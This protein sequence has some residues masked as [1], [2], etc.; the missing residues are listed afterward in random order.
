MPVDS[1]SSTRILPDRWTNAP[2]GNILRLR[3]NGEDG[4]VYYLSMNYLRFMTITNGMT[5]VRHAGAAFMALALV[6]AIGLVPQPARAA[7]LFSDGFEAPTNLGNWAAGSAWNS[8]ASAAHSGSKSARVTGGNSNQTMEKTISTAGYTTLTLSF[9]YKAD[10][11]ESYEDDRVEVY[12]S[13]NG[14][15]TWTEITSAQMDD[16]HD[17]NTWRQVTFSSFPSGANNNANFKL[18]FKGYLNSGTDK[19]WIDDVNLS[20]TAVSVTYAL[21]ITKG[22]VGSGSVTSVPTGISCGA[23][24]AENY[25]A[26]T[27]VTLTATPTTG[28]TFTGWSGACSGTGS[29]VVTMDAAKSVTATFAIATYPLTV[30]TSGSGS[31]TSVPTGISRGADC[32]ENFSFG[33]NVTLTATPT[34]GW[35][36]TGWSGACSGTGSCVVSMTDATAV[37]ATFSTLPACSDGADNDEDTFVDAQDP[38]CWTDPN[39]AETYNSADTD[40]TTPGDM[41][42]NIEG[43]QLTDDLCP[44]PSTITVTKVVSGGTLTVGDFPLF[45]GETS[46]LSGITNAFAEGVYTISETPKLDYV[47]TFSGDCSPDKENGDRIDQIDDWNAKKEAVQHAIDESS[48]DDDSARLAQIEGIN[49]KILALLGALTATVDLSEGEDA[50][51]VIT[52]TFDDSGFCEIGY[53]AEEVIPQQQPPFAPSCPEGY[54]FVEGSCVASVAPTCDSGTY[55]PETNQCVTPPVEEG[56]SETVSAPTCSIGSLNPETD[57][58]DTTETPSCPEGAPYNSETNQCVPPV[59]SPEPI[60]MCVPNEV[61][62]VDICPNLDG[63]Q[64][65]V[66]EGKRLRDGQCLTAHNRSGGS[67]AS[68]GSTGRGQV[69][70]AATCTPLLTSYILPKQENDPE[71][72]K[73]LQDFLNTELSLSLPVTGSFDEVT[74]DAVKQFQKKYWEDVLKPWF[75]IPNSGITNEGEATGYVY[76]TTKWKINTIFCADSEAFPS[77]LN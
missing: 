47:P 35:S 45:V 27:N 1:N 18:R 53:H 7:T 39:N 65:E 10:D 23:D 76:K 38:G 20:G 28:S 67:T 66:P 36:F 59:P 68:T 25:A 58:C 48:D 21:T 33:T 8:D 54:T 55:N 29:C 42:P 24:C 22:G 51:C 9:W 14:G 3:S 60:V 49:E 77:T 71:E 73:K 19:V 2:S 32:A 4:F 52:N 12:Y 61:P 15:S 50:S 74:Q 6:T 70:G 16:A 41:C 40:E 64:T 44:A 34:S 13:T 11:L 69:L 5:L 62:K 26:S 43:I 56:G 17:D 46:V 37:V 57:M 31:V 72:V 30:S 75:S 63:I